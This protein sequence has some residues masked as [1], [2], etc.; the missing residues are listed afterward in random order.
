MMRT[1]ASSPARPA[2]GL[3]DGGLDSKSVVC[4][5]IASVMPTEKL[6]P[7]ERARM[8]VDSVAKTAEPIP[9]AVID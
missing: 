1:P 8:V 4:G 3:V 7:E 6:T 9:A 5:T 2:L